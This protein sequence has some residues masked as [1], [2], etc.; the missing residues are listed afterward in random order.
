M[1][2][3]PEL[4]ILFVAASCATLRAETVFHV[5][6]SGHDT[7]VGS[8]EKPFATL[9]R[10]RDAVRS[11]VAKGLNADVSVVLRAGRY[12]LSAPLVLDPR[13]SGTQTYGI[14][15]QARPGENVEISGGRR[16]RTAWQRVAGDLWKTSL[17]ETA[18]GPWEFRRLSVAGQRAQRARAPN[19]G[20]YTVTAVDEAR[21]MLTVGETLP[22]GWRTIRGAE[23]NTTA[24]WHYNRQPLAEINP[25]RNIVT[26][27]RPIGTDVSRFRMTVQAHPRVWLENAREFLDSSGEWFLDLAT[28]ELFYQTS[29]GTDANALEFTAPVLRE[30]IAVRG[31]SSA[32]PVRNVRFIGLTFRDTDWEMTAQE[33][34]GVQAGAWAADLSRTFMP[35]GALTLEYAEGCAVEKSRFND[36]GEGAIAVQ[37][38]CRNSRIVRNEFTRVGANV[39]QIAHMPEYTGR[40]H[41]LHADYDDPADVPSGTEI[42][43]NSI[44]G[45]GDVDFG[46]VGI[47][48]GYARQ[49]HI[50]HN[51]LRDL[52]YSGISV[53]WRWAAGESNCRENVIE[54]NQVERVMQQAGDGAGIYLVGE[55]RGTKVLNNYI[56]DSGRNYWS[57]GIYP[58]EYSA[59]M[60]VAHNFVTKQMDHSIFL[61]KNGAGQNIH[62]NNGEPGPTAF[63]EKDNGVRRWTVFNPAREPDDPSRYGPRPL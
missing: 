17:T 61:H 49:T 26:A 21:R 38:G 15:W 51:L 59:H 30:L 14:T 6:P 22:A 52:P 9:Q 60:E 46:S 16:L 18:G 56:H 27:V 4:L 3:L 34:L 23:L 40:G 24:H 58:D 35:P 19:T 54:W 7:A 20:Y 44:V 41:P 48:V 8:A 42:T 1:K 55:Q 57:H 12:E 28:G 36:L 25:E 32:E 29:P 50:A 39:I 63:Q 10:A 33:R 11:E 2:A 5:A 13:D 62:D 47:L 45:C 53:G 31:R 43:D 37:R